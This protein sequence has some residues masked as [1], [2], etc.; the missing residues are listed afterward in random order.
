MPRESKHTMITASADSTATAGATSPKAD[1]I[2]QF[3]NRQ[4][5]ML[6][7]CRYLPNFLASSSSLINLRSWSRFG[8]A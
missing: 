1:S 4:I 2:T 8:T 6:T 3:Q 7:T 5:C